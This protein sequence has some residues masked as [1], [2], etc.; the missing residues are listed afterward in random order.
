[1]TDGLNDLERARL[2]DLL[3]HHTDTRSAAFMHGRLIEVPAP[4]ST[5]NYDLSVSEQQALQRSPADWY[6]WAGRFERD[7]KRVWDL[8]E[9]AKA[10]GFRQASLV[11]TAL[12]T[13]DRISP[14]I[15]RSHRF[16]AERVVDPDWNG[17]FT[18]WPYLCDYLEQW[19]T[20]NTS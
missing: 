6:T 13:T 12:L 9:Q 11:D 7:E 16:L 8:L 14:E 5:T 10:Q 19:L 20:Q 17:C 2:Q 4:D 3:S 1:M 18:D 15:L